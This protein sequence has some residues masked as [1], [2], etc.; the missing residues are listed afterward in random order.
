M[1]DEQSQE[2][3]EE[4]D[5]NVLAIEEEAVG[6]AE[7]GAESIDDE[8]ERE[9]DATATREADATAARRPWRGRKGAEPED[10]SI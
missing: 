4:P 6:L 10:R 9:A 5:K 8:R 3:E 2:R 1:N 7:L